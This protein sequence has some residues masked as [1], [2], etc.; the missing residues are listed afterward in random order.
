MGEYIK[1]IATGEEIKIGVMDGIPGLIRKD[2]AIPVPL[3]DSKQILP[4]IV[5]KF[6]LAFPRS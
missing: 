3:G 1:N 6:C 4:A 5:V 2:F